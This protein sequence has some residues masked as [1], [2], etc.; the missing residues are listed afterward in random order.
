[1][2]LRPVAELAGMGKDTLNRIERGLLSP[3]LAQL[4]ALAEVLHTSVSELTRLPFPAP[5]N[6]ETDS[7][8]KAVRRALRDTG[9][10]RPGG[11]VLPVEALRSRV[12]AT[13]AAHSRCDREREIGAHCQV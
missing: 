9:H 1:M 4:Y 13:V 5:A 2:S 7:A 6:G 10:G 11:Q 3:T 8:I 12:Q